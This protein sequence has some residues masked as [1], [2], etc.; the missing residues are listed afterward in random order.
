MENFPEARIAMCKC[1]ETKK[2]YGVRFERYRDGW[3]YTWAFPIKESVAKREKYDETM[4]KG[5][6]YQDEDYPGC[7]YCGTKGFVICGQ[8]DGLMCNNFGSEPFKCEWCG[9]EGGTMVDYDGSGFKSG[10]DL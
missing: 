10:A 6:L 4:L 2:A 9:S 3:K 8:C 7:P 1:R 5:N